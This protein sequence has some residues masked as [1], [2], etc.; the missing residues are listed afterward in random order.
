MFVGHEITSLT[1]RVTARTE[2]ALMI[3]A[4]AHAGC[5]QGEWVRGQFIQDP[6]LPCLN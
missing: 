6:C 3:D 5:V 4:R 1:T 2:Y